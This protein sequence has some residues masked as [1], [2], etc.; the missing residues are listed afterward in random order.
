MLLPC[1]PNAAA[2]PPYPLHPLHPSTA[3]SPEQPPPARSPVA[4]VATAAAARVA[5]RAR[6]AD[7]KEALE[8]SAEALR[9]LQQQ[10]LEFDS[11]DDESQRLKEQL[12]ED[13]K[14]I[15]E[16]LKE[17]PY[18]DPAE[19]WIPQPCAHPLVAAHGEVTK[20][21]IEAE[22][23]RLS[24]ETSL[25]P[26][27]ATAAQLRRSELHLRLF[28]VSQ[29]EE[30]LQRAHPLLEGQERFIAEELLTNC[31]MCESLKR[32]PSMTGEIGAEEARLLEDFGRR[33]RECQYDPATVLRCTGATSLIDFSDDAQLPGFAQRC[34]ERQQSAEEEDR[35]LVYFIQVFLLRRQEPLE[36]LC[37]L[38]GEECCKLLLELQVVSCIRDPYHLLSIDDAV[39]AVSSDASG[40]RCFSNLRL[41]PRDDLLVATDA[42]TWPDPSVGFEPVMY[43][44]DDSLALLAAKPEV[45]EKNLLDLC[46]GSGVQGIAALQRGASSV[47]FSDVNPRA[48]R[49]VRFNL[50]LNALSS[51]QYRCCLGDAY[52]QVEGD[53]F[54]G[55]LANPPFLP[56]PD[57]IASQAV[58]L[59]GNGGAFGEDV[60]RKIVAKAPEHLVPGGWLLMVTYAPNAEEM[61]RRLQRYLT[62]RAALSLRLRV[63]AGNEREAEEFLPVASEVESYFYPKALDEVGVKTLAEALVFLRCDGDSLGRD[64]GASLELREELFADE[65]YLRQFGRQTQLKQ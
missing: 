28:Q 36:T 1:H 62:D 30:L 64:G 21:L 59:Y 60:L 16:A 20:A 37:E 5:R 43:L 57:N 8:R 3:R 7:A 50:A 6:A 56:N 45:K 25:E 12:T 32:R 35:G 40:I 61:P 24:C 39:A 55:I 41:W 34:W 48:L 47:T 49:F 53:K 22:L 54:D 14:R 29:A 42:Q 44:S 33:M 46:C 52:A 38:L 4:A 2:F 58:A 51:K 26:R 63:A 27:A 15:R 9:K 23:A 13:E 11:G 19:T 10:W 65:D 31:F 18:G 17:C